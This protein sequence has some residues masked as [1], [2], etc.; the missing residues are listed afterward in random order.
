MCAANTEK[1]F[2]L[3]MLEINGVVI[4]KCEQVRNKPGYNPRY[5]A[6]R[7]G[8]SSPGKSAVHTGLEQIV[9]VHPNQRRGGGENESRATSGVSSRVA[10]RR[11]K[12]DANTVNEQGS[13]DH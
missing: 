4:G 13:I 10:T 3:D 2:V 8:N 1:Y 9:Q 6:W 7:S 5:L 12:Q 11:T